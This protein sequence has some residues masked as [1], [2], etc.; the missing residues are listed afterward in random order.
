MKN[1]VEQLVDIYFRDEWWH[2]FKMPYPEAVN[3]HGQMLL[4]GNIKTVEDLGVVLGYVEFWLITKEQLNRIILNKPFDAR[5]EDVLNG[6][7]AYVANLWI[8]KSFRKGRVF[9][10]LSA[11]F[12]DRVKHC[13]MVCGEEQPRKGRLRV[14]KNTKTEQM[15][16]EKKKVLL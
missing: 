9:R 16:W 12:F 5:K 7:I 3:Y 15:Q 2:N 14:F 13:S 4:Q 8:D 1:T 6:D 10:E 11:R